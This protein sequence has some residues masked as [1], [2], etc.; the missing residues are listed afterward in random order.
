MVDT[1]DSI[2]CYKFSHFITRSL[3]LFGISYLTGITDS[4]FTFVPKF[5]I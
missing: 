5:F 3:I 1:G 2:P 4:D